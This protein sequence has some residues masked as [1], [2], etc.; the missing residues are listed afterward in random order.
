MMQAILEVDQ[1]TVRFGAQYAV[2]DL[3]FAVH[4]NE[5]LALVGESGCGKST[6][7]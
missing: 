7:W 1:L 4:E 5:M 6:I 3:S 2:K